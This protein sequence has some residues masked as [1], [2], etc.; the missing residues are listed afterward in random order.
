MSFATAA[1][2][3]TRL[4]RDLTDAETDQV[5]SVIEIV[6]GL[7]RDAVDRDADWDP[8]PVP[9]ALKELCIQKAISAIANP[10]N[11]AAYSESLGA[12]SYST[13]FQRSQDGG[14][15]LSE[16]EGRACRLAVYGTNA[17]SGS[18]R[19]MID[20]S[21]DLRENRDVDEPEE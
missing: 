9:A 15:F 7:I 17:G 21:I 19:S 11:V 1:H 6:D 10:Q 14:L 4:G 8:D 3:S 12:H 13:T 16:A 2:V 5:E 20:R 18:S